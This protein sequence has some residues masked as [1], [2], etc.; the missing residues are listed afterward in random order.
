MT[1]GLYL[2]RA[3]LRPLLIEKLQI[4]GQAGLMQTIEN[5]PGFPEEIRGLDL[6]SRIGDQATELGLEIVSSSE[7][8]EIKKESEEDL[9][10]QQYLQTSPTIL[11][12]IDNEKSALAPNPTNKIFLVI[13]E[14]GT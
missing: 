2:A 11:R 1:A 14:F 9:I 8:R 5:F 3:K 6:V 7:A 10:S 4:G 12:K 13:E